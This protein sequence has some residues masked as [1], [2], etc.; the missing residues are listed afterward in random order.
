MEETMRKILK[1]LFV[2]AAFALVAGAG[3]AAPAKADLYL[4]F[5]VP[6]HYSTPYYYLPPSYYS[7]YSP[8]AYYYA[9]RCY[10]DA[11]GRVCY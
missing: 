1:S 7:P 9:P 6:F 11:Y 8:P 3:M 5:G 10:W 2:P 4:N